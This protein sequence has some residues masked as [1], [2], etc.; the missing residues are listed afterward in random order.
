MPKCDRDSMPRRLTP[1]WHLAMLLFCLCMGCR[2]P[3][4]SIA[5]SDLAER[6]P[7]FEEILKIDVHAH[8]FE[9]M[10]QLIEM[11]R[12]NNVSIINVCNRGR[13]GHLETMHRIARQMYRSHPDLLP[14]ASCF[15]LTRIEEPDYTNQVIAWLDGTFKDGAVMTKIWKEVGMELRRRDGSFVLPDDQVFDPIYEFLAAC[16]KPLMAHLAISGPHSLWRG[17]DLET[18]SRKEPAGR[19]ATQ[20][21]HQRS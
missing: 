9:E 8:I 18:L 13:D 19:P 10:P 2:N 11:M 14:F 12:R 15:D 20:F 3:Q 5:R 4:S 6:A 7:A 21:L 1:V 16:G 17:L